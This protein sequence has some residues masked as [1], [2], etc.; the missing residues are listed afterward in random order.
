MIGV[1]LMRDAVVLAAEAFAAGPRD[2]A[3]GANDPT[4]ADRRQHLIHQ[5]GV[6]PPFEAWRL[7]SL[8]S[9]LVQLAIAA[10]L[11]PE[12]GAAISLIAEEPRCE[13]PSPRLFAWLMQ[14]LLDAPYTSSLAMALDGG[15]PASIGLLQATEPAAGEPKLRQPLRPTPAALR[16]V[17]GR[18]GAQRT[19]H[20]VHEI[21]PPAV[22]ACSKLRA[23]AA[24]KRL[25]ERRLLVL[26]AASPRAARQ[27]ALDIACILRRQVQL[28]QPTDL[29]PVVSL[30]APGPHLTVLNLFALADPRSL[31]SG[32]LGELHDGQPDTIV[33]APETLRTPGQATIDAPPL[34][35]AA[36]TRLWRAFVPR[37]SAPGMA[38]R[39]RVSWDELEEAGR[40]AGDGAEAGDAFAAEDA[41]AAQLLAEGR[42]AMGQ[43]VDAV[44]PQTGLERLVV[45]PDVRAKLCDI[46]RSHAAAPIVYGEMG[47]GADSPHGRGLTCLFSGKPGTGKTFAAQCLAHE[48]GLNLYHVD[49]AQVVSKYIGETEKALSEIFREAE[50]GHGILLFDEADAL[51]GKRSE[52]KDAHDRYAN[53]E[54]GYLLQELESFEGVV[55]LT[56][57]LRGN[58]DSAFMRRLRF[59]VDFPMPDQEQ[60]RRLWDQSLPPP[61][62]RAPDLDIDLFAA[63]FPLAGGNIRNVG[64]AAAHFA[65][66]GTV[67]NRELIRATLRELEKTGRPCNPEQFGPL[68]ALVAEATR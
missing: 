65:V 40:A 4:L 50:A 37:R 19:G 5:M 29:P 27:F 47:L 8:E 61:A 33:L 44:R 58:I 7:D 17:L 14:W 39:F 41:M 62:W 52:V 55:I 35:H 38:G 2:G 56:T 64:L 32:W 20:A 24:A 6:A 9:W 23:A 3:I 42:R 11:H 25:E 22:S 16:L 26:R 36:A 31:P 51:F 48:L 30:R 46:L 63:R 49:L 21:A 1:S 15:R 59:I 10:E 13:L 53:I 68:S 18:D 60:R 12:A 28:H 45:P 57:N 34:D 66:P 67:G 43:R 54:V